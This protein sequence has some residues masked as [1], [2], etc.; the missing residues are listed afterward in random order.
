MLCL[1]DRN[2]NCTLC[3]TSSWFWISYAYCKFE[4]RGCGD[5][6]HTSSR[7]I[8]FRDGCIHVRCVCIRRDEVFYRYRRIYGRW[9]LW[10]LILLYELILQIPNLV[11]F[12]WMLWVTKVGGTCTVCICDT[13]LGKLLEWNFGKLIITNN[14][15]LQHTPMLY[16]CSLCAGLAC[17]LLDPVIVAAG[18]VG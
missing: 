2:V 11:M 1:F 8:C 13:C 6:V 16:L 17:L 4:I 10:L 3:K 5:I 14:L 18:T 12:P 15:I 7:G 9:F